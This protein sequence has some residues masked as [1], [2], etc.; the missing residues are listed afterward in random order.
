MSKKIR[1]YLG[2]LAYTITGLIFGFA[3]FLLFLNIYHTS[4]V[5]SKYVKSSEEID[6]YNDFL[7]N[8]TL[9]KNKIDKINLNDEKQINI[10][11]LIIYTKLL[12]I[13]NN[14][15]TFIYYIN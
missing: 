10:S 8:L 7:G 12:I 5:N 3:F 6:A 4:E 13:I 2:L 1:N 9:L 14:R 11:N 15:N